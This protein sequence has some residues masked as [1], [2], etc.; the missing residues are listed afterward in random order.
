[1]DLLVISNETLEASRRYGAALRRAGDVEAEVGK[2][3][4]KKRSLRRADKVD[5]G[6]AEIGHPR[7]LLLNHCREMEEIV[8]TREAMQVYSGHQL[9]SRDAARDVAYHERRQ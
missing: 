4:R 8:G 3:S 5:E 1:M 6:I 9:I 7:R 2:P